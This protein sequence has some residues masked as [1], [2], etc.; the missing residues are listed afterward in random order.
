MDALITY[1]VSAMQAQAKAA[2]KARGYFDRWDSNGVTYYL[3]NTTLWKQDTELS[4]ALADIKAVAA[5]TCL[6][7][8]GSR[9]KR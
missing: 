9:D 7:I 5:V 2:M 1:D 3:P 6:P 4:A 8:F